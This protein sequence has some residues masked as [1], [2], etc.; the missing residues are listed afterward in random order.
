MQPEERQ[1]MAGPPAQAPVPGH[2]DRPGRR[3]L[4]ALTA[5]MKQYG[6]T[7]ALDGVDLALYP[8]EVVGIIGHNGAGKSTLMRVVMGLTQPDSGTVSA[9]DR[10]EVTGGYS[11]RAA[12]DLGFRIVFQ[13]GALAPSLRLF[14]NA[15][16]ARPAGRGRGWRRRMRAAMR[17]ALDEV[18]PGNAIPVRAPAGNLP[19]G[20]RQMAEIAQACLGGPAE[21]RLLVLDE[22]TSSLGR[23]ATECLF[24]HLRRLRAAGVCVILISHR[25]NEIV[26][27]TDRVLVLRD[28]KLVG[29]RESSRV[30]A[31]ELVAMMGASQAQAGTR[32]RRVPSG[33]PLLAVNGLSTG[34]LD[35]VSV[36]LRR[37]EI[38]GLAGLDGQGQHEL[39]LE[40]WRRRRRIRSGGRVAFVTGDRQAAGI[41]PL[42]DVTANVAIA[43]L[44]GLAG[45]GIRRPSAERALAER[46]ISRLV[47]RGGPGTGITRLSGGTQQK[48]LL[49]RAMATA[50]DLVL[51]DDPFRGVDV[52]TKRDTYRLMHSEADAGRCFLWFTTENAELEECDRVYVLHE[53]R[54]VAELAGADVSEER[55][56]AAS[57]AVGHPAVGE[58]GPR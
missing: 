6:P 3:P 23:E 15:V 16:V 37:G 11:I 50:A 40:L 25:L 46:W 44:R 7:R 29:E 4:L 19:I 12:H 36:A 5:I 31:E 39:L 58:G 8:G 21:V 55:V 43:S 53:G 35:Q 26:A 42:W 20:Q 33:E 30:T 1:A 18:F 45:W 2:G 13:E 10:G 27:N 54:V 49:A 38:V 41:F 22:P 32:T 34:I 56:V 14:E 52:G 9:A 47:I 17:L 51:L 48:V 24:A 28:G 57:F